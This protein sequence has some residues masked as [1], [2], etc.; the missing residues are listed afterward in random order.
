MGIYVAL[1]ITRVAIGKILAKLVKRAAIHIVT[2]L[3]ALLKNG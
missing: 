1:A 3:I 2:T